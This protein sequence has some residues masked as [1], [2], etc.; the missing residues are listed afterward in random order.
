MKQKLFLAV[1]LLMSIEV[2]SGCPTEGESG[3]KSTDQELM[4]ELRV[5]LQEAR[6]SFRED[7][8]GFLR[9]RSE[10][11]AAAKKI[12]ENL[13]KEL[14]SGVVVT[15]DDAETTQY[16]RSML[17][18]IRMKYRIEKKTDGEWTRWYPQ[19]EEQRKSIP[20]RVIEHV[21][22]EKKKQ[23]STKCKEGE[24]VSTTPLNQTRAEKIPSPC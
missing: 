23:L 7:E 10:D 9:Y 16:L 24:S 21:F 20:M 15:Y 3:F 1:T 11:V 6:I 14:H 17:T 4:R 12:R 5:A 19:T 8:E 13:E 22:E 18:S 2:L